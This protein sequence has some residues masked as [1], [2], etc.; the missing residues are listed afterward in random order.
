ME[1]RRLLSLLPMLAVP[2]ALAQAP[3][4]MGLLV[5]GAPPLQ[6]PLLRP[7]LDA[8]AQIGLVEGRDFVLEPRFAEGQLGRLPALAA[9][10]VALRCDLIFAGGGVAAAAAQR[11]TG[12]IPIVFAIVTDPVALGLVAS[13]ERPGGNITGAT[14]LDPRQAEA[15]FALLRQVMPAIERVAILSDDTIPGGDAEGHAP[16]DRAN[17]AAA[18]ALGI[19]PQLVK[20]RGA[21]PGRP[22][23][24]FEAA[25]DAMA[26]GRAQA[27]VVLDTPIPFAARQRIGQLALSRRLPSVFAGGLRD[28][29]GVITYG[30]SVV[31]TWPL[32]APQIERIWKGESPATIPVRFLERRELVFNLRSAEATGVTI[33]PDLLALADTVIR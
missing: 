10:L 30:T 5:N 32:T 3:R 31:E 8:L 14:S 9:E 20:L 12:S 4:R 2:R 6:Q 1:R 23:V 11:A 7:F 28:G 18:R 29:G 17:I 13:A 24:D 25:F 15:Q 26:A 16:I 22:E 27:V 19:V 33:P 21:G